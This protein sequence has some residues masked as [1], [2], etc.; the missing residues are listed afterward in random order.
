MKKQ[1]E[2]TK[3]TRQAFVD[4][5]C[6]IYAH[7]PIEK[8]SIQE[9]ANV[10]GYNRSTFYQYFA[11]IYELLSHTEDILLYYIKEG[12][13]K[14]GNST[15]AMR[16][17]LDCLES[18]AHL[19]LFTALLGDYGSAHFLER[20]KREL[21]LEELALDFPEHTAISPYLIEFYMSTA[22]SLF[23][24]WFRQEKDLPPEELARLIYTLYTSGISSM[25]G[26]KG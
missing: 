14:Q 5:F 21:P 25:L 4:A 11:D 9:I 19:S 26:D 2:L 15:H 3:K 20:L 10:A 24:F 23:R 18:P 1:P 6:A 7:K 17:A 22:L 8:I 13:A 12:L 16:G